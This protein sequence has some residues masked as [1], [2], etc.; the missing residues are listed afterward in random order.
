MLKS[1]VTGKAMLSGK[2]LT[3]WPKEWIGGS[4]KDY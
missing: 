2:I 4:K 1:K 3:D